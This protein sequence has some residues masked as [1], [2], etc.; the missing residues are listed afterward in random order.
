MAAM[1]TMAAMDAMAAMIN[2]RIFGMKKIKETNDN[3]LLR[4]FHHE[5]KYLCSFCNFRTH[6]KYNLKMHKKNKHGSPQ[7]ALGL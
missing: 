5:Q 7:T 6:K 4:V 1:A 2:L 3:E